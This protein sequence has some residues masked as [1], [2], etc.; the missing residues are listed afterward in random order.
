MLCISS[1]QSQREP[2]ESAHR[3]SSPQR[4]GLGLGRKE[5]LE[6]GL[7]AIERA[8]LEPPEEFGVGRDAVLDHD[9]IDRAFL[10]LLGVLV[11]QHRDLLVALG[12]DAVEPKLESE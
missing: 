1:L 7:A 11:A 10:E 8:L 12:V 6:I 3:P 9:L 4:R 5:R 2:G